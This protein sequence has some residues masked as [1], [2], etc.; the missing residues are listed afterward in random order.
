MG[1][2][3]SQW[4]DNREYYFRDVKEPEPVKRGTEVL[5]EALKKR[6]KDSGEVIPP[7]VKA[8]THVASLERELYLAN[9]AMGQY[10]A[11]LRDGVALDD[12]EMRLFMN[13]LT[14]CVS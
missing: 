13:L 9:L 10:E 1:R 11:K 14:P 12:T 5:A 8:P 3:N 7:E 2:E 6:R 4:K